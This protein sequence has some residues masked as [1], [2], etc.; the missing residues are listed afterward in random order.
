MKKIF[1]QFLPLAVSITLICGFVFVVMQQHIRASANEP[2]LSMVA[3]AVG[4]LMMSNGNYPD[5]VI[6]KEMIDPRFSTTPFIGV[7]NDAGEELSMNMTGTH[8]RF[9]QGVFDYTRINGEDRVTLQPSSQL[10]LAAVIAHYNAGYNN[11][12]SGFV[13]AARSLSEVDAQI[14]SLMKLCTALWFITLVAVF[15]TL[16]IQNKA[17]ATVAS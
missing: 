7:Y 9:P 8:P 12:K 3:D 16:W 14:V 6:P 15:A 17:H 4:A 5:I 11:T 1:R 2:Q 13:L 10:R